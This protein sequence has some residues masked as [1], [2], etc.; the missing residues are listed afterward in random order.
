MNLSIQH[1]LYSN[2]SKDLSEKDYYPFGMLM[3]GRNF[4]SEN[5]RFGFNTQEKVDEISGSGNHNTALF[6]EYDTRLAKRWNLDPKPIVG[7]SEYSV[8]NLNPILYFDA[9]GDSADFYNRQ[10]QKVETDHIDDKKAYIQNDDGKKEFKGVNYTE[11]LGGTEAIK[12]KYGEGFNKVDDNFQLYALGYVEEAMLELNEQIALHRESNAFNVT[13]QFFMDESKYGWLDFKYKIAGIEPRDAAPKVGQTK[14]SILPKTQTMYLVGNYYMN[15]GTAGNFLWG[16]AGQK[17][18]IS[19]ATLKGLAH[20]GTLLTNLTK[21]KLDSPWDQ[22]AI[23]M[24]YG[25]AKNS[26]WTQT[27]IMVDRK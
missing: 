23:G 1:H 2:T 8:M 11:V 15:V 26:S 21:L 3:L 6:W 20:G 12:G 25:L 18:G 5:Y 24:G 16:Y 13:Q 27:D 19:I 9:R 17:T 10:G 4:T 14:A 22:K 7:T